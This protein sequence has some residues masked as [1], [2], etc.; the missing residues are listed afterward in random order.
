LR[1]KDT[2]QMTLEKTFAA[3]ALVGA[4]SVMAAVPPDDLATA[5]KLASAID[6]A[7]MTLPT[8]VRQG[9][10]TDYRKFISSPVEAQ[11]DKIKALPQPRRMELVQCVSAGNEFLNRAGDSMKAQ[12][13]KPAGSLES[14][15]LSACKALK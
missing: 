8:A 11:L 7:A 5:K 10:M 1:Q 2:R 13:V 9:D 14:E 12:K 15:S 6:L 4:T 3:F